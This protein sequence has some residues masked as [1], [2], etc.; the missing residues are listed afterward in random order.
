MKR[1]FPIAALF[2][3]LITPSF[4]H[5]QL[6]S[7]YFTRLPGVGGVGG[8]EGG[9]RVYYGPTSGDMEFEF[10]GS[11]IRMTDSTEDRTDFF[12]TYEVN[13]EALYP[14]RPEPNAFALHYTGCYQRF[15]CTALCTYIPECDGAMSFINKIV[16]IEGVGFVVPGPSAIPPY[17]ADHKYHVV[18]SV[19]YNPGYITFGVGVSG[20]TYDGWED[21]PTGV[22]HNLTYAPTPTLRRTWGSLKS[23][24]R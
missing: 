12:Y 7:D 17:R 18:A 10:S 2:V 21:T 8:T 9:Y 11:W 1:F 19:G 14:P 4:V 3:C 15:H 6:V 23:L 16:F 5:A 13:G 20:Y 22:V 24:Y